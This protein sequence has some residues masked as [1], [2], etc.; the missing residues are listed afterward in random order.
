M[1]PVNSFIYKSY[2][3]LLVVV[4]SWCFCYLLYFF[5][6][7]LF[8]FSLKCY[9]WHSNVNAVQIGETLLIVAS[10][11]VQLSLQVY[12]LG[13]LTVAMRENSHRVGVSFF[14]VP[15]FRM[16]YLIYFPRRESCSFFRYIV[17]LITSGNR[18]ELLIYAAVLVPV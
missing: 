11:F 9:I 13:L 12:T 15:Q 5:S 6:L 8:L 17:K 16:R 18:R 2:C 7:H 3:L 1:W 4:S 14:F 10:Y